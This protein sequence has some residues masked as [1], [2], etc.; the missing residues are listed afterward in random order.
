[1]SR[2]QTAKPADEGVV[3]Q[4]PRTNVYTMML[5]LS[6]F[7]IITAIT[8]LAMLLNQYKPDYWKVTLAPSQPPAQML[9]EHQPFFPAAERFIA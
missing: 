7:A 9:A 8:L 6:L 5:M 3:V 4:K 2:R 1:V